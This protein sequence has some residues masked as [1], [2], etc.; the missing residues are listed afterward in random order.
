NIPK[1]AIST[2]VNSFARAFTDEQQPAS[3]FPI[4]PRSTADHDLPCRVALGPLFAPEEGGILPMVGLGVDVF[5][6]FSGRG[7]RVGEGWP[8]LDSAQDQFDCG[9]LGLWDAAVA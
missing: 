4:R 9:C 2:G 1:I 3:L 8:R 5:R 7:H 6:P